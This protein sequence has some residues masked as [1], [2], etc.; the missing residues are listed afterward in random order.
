MADQGETRESPGAEGEPFVLEGELVD[1]GEGA[2]QGCPLEGCWRLI[3]VEAFG[4]EIPALSI[5][6]QAIFWEFNGNRLVHRPEIG[7]ARESK[8]ELDSATTPGQIAVT[9]AGGRPKYGIYSVE[10]GRLKIGM[11]KD[12]D[13][14]PTGFATRAGDGLRILVFSREASSPGFG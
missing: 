5:R 13:Q 9:P 3:A 6:Q 8:F 11:Y 1:V 14:P 2:A 12:K 7:R 4:R 10:N